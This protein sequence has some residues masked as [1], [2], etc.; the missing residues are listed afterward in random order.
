ME[1][2]AGYR[3]A[4]AGEK[5]FFGCL[6]FAILRQ[7]WLQVPRHH[8]SWDSP[9]NFGGSAKANSQQLRDPG[10]RMM[11]SR[12]FIRELKTVL[13]GAMSLSGCSSRL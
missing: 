6:D 5:K 1:L 4:A 3:R 8:W 7:G 12:L 13:R 11:T 9:D 10:I 2:H